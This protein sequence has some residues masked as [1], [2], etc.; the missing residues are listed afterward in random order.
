MR[1][2]LLDVNV[3]I[4]L[5]WPAHEHHEGAHRWFGSRGK[6]HWATCPL[7][8]LAFVRIVSSPAFS[9][10]A[11]A[12]SEALALL[13]RNLAHPGHEFWPDDVGL[14]NAVGPVAGRLQGSRQLTDAYLLGLASRRHGLLASFDRGLRSLA[15]GGRLSTLELVPTESTRTG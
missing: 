3:L 7:T 15:P 1:T 2:T 14:G 11:L 5:L 13:D 10:D 9:S 12:P 6:T 4:A 8:Q